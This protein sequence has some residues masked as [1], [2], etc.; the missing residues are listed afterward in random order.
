MYKGTGKLVGFFILLFCFPCPVSPQ[1]KSPSRLRNNSEEPVECGN[2]TRALRNY[3]FPIP[4]FHHAASSPALWK[5]SRSEWFSS[6]HIFPNLSFPSLVKPET[7]HLPL[8][9]LRSMNSALSKGRFEDSY[10]HSALSFTMYSSICI[11][12]FTCL[13]FCFVSF[14]LHLYLFF[15]LSL[16][17]SK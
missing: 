10:Y 17:P 2:G 7:P 15:Y 3:V 1:L 8:Y 11:W 16:K 5:Q 12:H 4:L 6:I 13:S 9:F 14:Y